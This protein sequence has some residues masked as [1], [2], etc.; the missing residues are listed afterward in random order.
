MYNIG[1]KVVYIDEVGGGEVLQVKATTLVIES[2]DGFDYEVPMAA[3]TLVNEAQEK[4]IEKDENWPEPEVLDE[5]AEITTST[6]SKTKD[7]KSGETIWEV[8][9]HIEELVRSPE[10]LS[11]VMM[12]KIQLEQVE[13][14]LYKAFDN[15]IG[16]VVFIHGVGQGVLKNNI[17]K[18]LKQ[19][20]NVY[21]DDADFM[22]YGKGAT[23]V[24]INKL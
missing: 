6:I 10:K 18:V 23:L 8:D 11:Q 24:I 2:D 4:W 1:D 17:H 19:Y 14:V 16:K 5:Y 12:L 9:L 20:E 15:Y 13:T 3:V 21:F 22:T 7:K